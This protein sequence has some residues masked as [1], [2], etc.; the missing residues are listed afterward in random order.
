M[1]GPLEALS[2]VGW[3]RLGV[4]AYPALGVSAAVGGG[5]VRWHNYVERL[6]GVYS[7]RF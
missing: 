6:T 4:E 7:W 2:Q 5:A 3:V 1:G